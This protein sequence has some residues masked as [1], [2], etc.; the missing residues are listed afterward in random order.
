MED[1][2]LRFRFSDELYKGLEMYQG[3][4]GRYL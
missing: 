4:M 3:K 1:V 2:R